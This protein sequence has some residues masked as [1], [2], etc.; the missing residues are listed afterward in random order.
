MNH[1]VHTVTVGVLATGIMDA[2][3]F[4]REPLVGFPRADYRLIGR[5]FAYMPRGQFR[6]AAIRQS[7]SLPFE[8]LIGWSVHYAI[9]ISFALLLV[10]LTGPAWLARPTLGPAL[11]VGLATLAAPLLVMQPAMGA[12]LAGAR[13]PNPTAARL[14]SLITHLVYGAGLYAAA[15]LLKIIVSR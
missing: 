4:A 3:G 7:P 8:H 13:L 15:T 5:W 9:G 12:G 2:W 11:L 10:T 6:H 1:Y 14:Q